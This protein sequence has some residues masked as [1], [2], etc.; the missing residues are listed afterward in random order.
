[1]IERACQDLKEFTAAAQNQNEHSG[2]FVSVNIFSRQFQDLHF[3]EHLTDT[4]KKF[5]LRNSQI[6]L[7][8]TERI[9]ME[10]PNALQLLKSAE[11]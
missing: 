7:E 1:M 6:K 2:L 5:G 8:V 10:G 11:S 4:V 3:F 9:F